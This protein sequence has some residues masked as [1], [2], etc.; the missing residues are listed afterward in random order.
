MWLF[1][2]F[3][4][5]RKYEVLKLN[6]PCIFSSKNINI[7]KGAYMKYVGRGRAEGFTNFSENF[8]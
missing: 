2:Y 1:Y 8:S 7:D 3:S 6:I 4:F 5:E